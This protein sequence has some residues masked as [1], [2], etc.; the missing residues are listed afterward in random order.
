MAGHTTETTPSAGQ[1]VG[2]PSAMGE[3]DGPEELSPRHFFV[4]RWVQ[5]WEERFGEHGLL[6]KAG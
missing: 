2:K 4:W 6:M 3:R 1:L 5:R